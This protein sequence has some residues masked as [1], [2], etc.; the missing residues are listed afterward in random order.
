MGKGILGKEKG[1]GE[2][3]DQFVMSRIMKNWRCLCPKTLSLRC[4]KLL[5]CHER[6]SAMSPVCSVN[7]GPLLTL[8]KHF[9]T[10]GFTWEPPVNTQEHSEHFACTTCMR[11]TPFLE[12]LFAPSDQHA[13]PRLMSVP[14][15]HCF[16]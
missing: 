7:V 13:L 14:L 5:W 3:L 11:C 6:V 2:H 9:V 16:M 12:L 8:L 1:M 4:K 10:S 15:G